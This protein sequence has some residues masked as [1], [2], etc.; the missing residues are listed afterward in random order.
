[1]ALIRDK[2]LLFA[3]ILAGAH[4][5]TAFGADDISVSVNGRTYQCSSG[6]APQFKTVCNCEWVNVWALRLYRLNLTNG[7]QSFLMDRGSFGSD[8][9]ACR[10]AMVEDPACH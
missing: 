3:F 1:M 2:T 7:Q 6:S 9:E 10:T 8:F 5:N 4:A